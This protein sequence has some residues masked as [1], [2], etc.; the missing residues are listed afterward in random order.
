MNTLIYKTNQIIIIDFTNGYVFPFPKLYYSSLKSF[1]LNSKFQLNERDNTHQST[2]GLFVLKLG[3]FIITFSILSYCP[4]LL[5]YHI[6]MQL[7]RNHFP[8]P[9]RNLALGSIN[10]YFSTWKVPWINSL[11][12]FS[13][14]LVIW[15]LQGARKS[16]GI[17]KWQFS[18]SKLSIYWLKLKTGGV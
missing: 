3:N 6:I 10:Y 9:S 4:Q 8:N 7:W 16:W 15:F 5:C 11:T 18:H 17:L 2:Q 1:P 13:S 12:P 14:F